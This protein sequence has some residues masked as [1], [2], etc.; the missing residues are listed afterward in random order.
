MLQPPAS[1]P[2][3][4]SPTVSLSATLLIGVRMLL[5]WTVVLGVV[6]PLVITGFGF[7][8][9][10]QAQGSLV[11][12][13]DGSVVGSELIG[14]NFDGPTWFH[15]RPSAAGVG[16]D[17]LSSGASNLAATSSELAEIIVERRVRVAS[18]E[19]VSESQIPADALTASA[20]GL[21][22]HI[23]EEYARLQIPR[24]ARERNLSISEVTEL[25][26]ANL[27]GSV[28]GFIG[29]PRVNVVA[30]NMNLHMNLHMNLL[31]RQTGG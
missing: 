9:P 18:E 13:D 2:T 7:L 14:Q 8:M 3:T 21:D 12:T 15:S 1:S 30:L 29:Q 5:V 10:A 6:Y 17:A 27:Q 4:P 22:P 23:S 20:S 28:F 26:D 25:I 24:V 19:G 31:Q 16:Y 11:R